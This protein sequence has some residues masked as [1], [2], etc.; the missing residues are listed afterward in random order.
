MVS[1]FVPA[2]IFAAFDGNWPFG[3]FSDRDAGSP[4]NCG[5]F[6]DATGVGHDQRSVLHQTKEVQITQWVDQNN[7]VAVVPGIACVPVAL[8]GGRLEAGLEP[9][10]PDSLSGSRMYRKN[11]RAFCS[12]LFQPCQNVLKNMPVIHISRPM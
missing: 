4:Q 10:F 1:V 5:F 2:S 7:S 11:D 12:K 9:K 8:L 3:I 6:L